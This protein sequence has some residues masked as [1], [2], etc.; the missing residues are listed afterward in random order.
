MV[1]MKTLTIGEETYEIVDEKARDNIGPIEDLATTDKTSIVAAI[2]EVAKYGGGGE[3]DEA[4]VVEIV[5][6][7]LE[8]A[9]LD[10]FA[11]KDEVKEKA[12]D[13]LFE[14]DFRVGTAVGAFKV[15]DK[16]QNLTLKEI[17]TKILNAA[18]RENMIEKIISNEIPMLSGS[19]DGLVAMPFSLLTMTS[20]E[21]VAAPNSAGFYQIA[22]DGVVKESGYLIF[23][24]STG[25]KNY[26]MGII[27]G[28]KIVDIYMWDD[29][30][31]RWV[32]YSPVFTETEK[33]TVD[34]YSYAIYESDDSSSG[35]ILR[36]VIEE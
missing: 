25:R 3:V 5:D 31:Q 11:T 14:A 13:V 7:R 1:E 24:E 35:E 12:D 2:N 19:S 8:E 26:A 20:D 16:L 28:A 9:G 27:E 32:D 30:T 4:K 22:D 29:L 15:G 33:T 23:T 17:I 36:L 18:E 21:A 10:N 34:G 6:G